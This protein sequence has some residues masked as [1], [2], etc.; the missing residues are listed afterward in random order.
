MGKHGEFGWAARPPNSGP[1]LQWGRVGE[2]KWGILQGVIPED[3]VIPEDFWEDFL[4]GE[5]CIWRV[6]RT[7]ERRSERMDGRARTAGRPGILRD[8]L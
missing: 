5:S 4:G 7:S 1:S 8:L 3:D 6:D 2:G